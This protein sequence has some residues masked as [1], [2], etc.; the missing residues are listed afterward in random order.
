MEQEP[1]N[2]LSVD[3]VFSNFEGAIT[4]LVG[5][6]GNLK[7]TNYYER[8][9]W[10]F[11]DLTGGNIK[12]SRSNNPALLNSYNFNNTEV[13]DV[14]DMTGFYQIAYNT[15]YRANNV[16]TY[17][18][19]IPDASR[20]QKNRMLA[21]AYTFRALAH[22]DLVRVFAQPYNFSTN[23]TH[24]GIVIRTVNTLAT[25]PV[26]SPATVKE[27]YDQ[28]IFD[29]DSAITLYANSVDIYPGGTNKTWFSLDVARAIKMRVLL[30]KEDWEGVITLANLL[31]SPAYPLI[32]NGAYVN[33]WRRTA[34]VNMDQEAIFM[35][36]ARIDQNQG[37][38]GDNF[39]F[40]NTTFG[41]MASSNDLLGLLPPQDVRSRSNFFDSVRINNIPYYFTRKYQGRNDS[42]DNQ[43]LIRISEVFLSRA[44][45]YAELNN[46]PL[47][48]NDLN[49][50]RQRGNATLPILQSTNR[51]AVLDSIF[52]ERKRE[53]CFEGH[54]LFDVTRKKRNL[55][56]N[57]CIGANC[58]VSFPSPLFAVP[59]PIQR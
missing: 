41:Y 1:T 20:L 50:I 29:L 45:A 39:N 56:R 44:E 32:S 10:L 40:R 13:A 46:L 11:A 19:L 7:S 48:L 38:F 57:D 18:P 43:K 12:Y 8:N 17:A 4:T 16:L 21:D 26:G 53:L 25:V 31:I 24:E 27:V 55:V 47:A 5:T 59:R 52:L 49:R 2:R 14:N 6:Y 15:I 37:S 22:F 33:S 3:D 35:L 42:A 28:I 9:F 54:G 51:E 36:F 34:T 23:A 58:S 30:Y